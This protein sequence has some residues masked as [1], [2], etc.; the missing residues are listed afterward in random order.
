MQ[1]N[2]RPI[3]RPILQVPPPKWHRYPKYL[4]QVWLRSEFES[5]T[6]YIGTSGLKHETT[7]GIASFLSHNKVIKLHILS[8][9]KL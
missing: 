2:T 9:V 5:D 6:C 7:I 1:L 3:K 8:G 4:I